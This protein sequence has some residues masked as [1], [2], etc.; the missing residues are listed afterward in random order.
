MKLSEWGKRKQSHL[1]SMTF[2][3]NDFTHRNSKMLLNYKYEIR[4][5]FSLYDGISDVDF[6]T[7]S[8]PFLPI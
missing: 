1:M 4:D 3:D 2:S 7:Q 8:T 5:H 6:P